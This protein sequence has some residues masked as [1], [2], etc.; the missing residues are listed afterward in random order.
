M[1]NNPIGNN[2][3]FF[4]KIFTK[5]SKKKEDTYIGSIEGTIISENAI[6]GENAQSQKEIT[7]IASNVTIGKN[8]KIA[9]GSMI[10]KD[11]EE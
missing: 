8:V 2:K 10:E 4:G 5:N 6:V 9:K 11:V 7:V 1:T 3:N